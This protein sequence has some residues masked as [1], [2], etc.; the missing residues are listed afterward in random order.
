MSRANTVSDAASKA[1]VQASDAISKIAIVS[2]AASK[3]Q[4][5]AAAG[6]AAASDALSKIG[7]V[8]DAA[9]K[10]MS[11]ANTVSD[12]ASKAKAQASDAISKIAIVSDAA[13]D[14][15]S[16]V[17]VVS[18]AASKA[19]HTANLVAAPSADV[20]ATGMKISMAASEALT[21]GAACYINAQG[22]MAKADAD[23]ASLYPAVALALSTTASGA[24]AAFL[25]QGIAR[26]DAWNWT[27]GATL[28]LSKTAGVITATQPA[29]TDNVIQV[30]GIA[31]HAD[32]ILF[33]PSMDIMTHT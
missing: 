25:L 12:A 29:A 30:L 17:A 15:L 1:K 19:G 22:F 2:D 32:R 24:T 9:S 16:K 14:A 3:A 4:A 8:S 20:S 13:S 10:A 18:D 21:F 33:K 11:R 27:P 23:A 28:Y 6:S 7:V 31:T 26:N 5:K